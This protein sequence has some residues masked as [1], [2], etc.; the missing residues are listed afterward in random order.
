MNSKT[1]ITTAIPYVNAAPHIGFA[2]EAVQG[3]TYARFQR[4]ISND[5]FLAFGS[6]E[7][8][9]KNVQAAEKE[10]LKT[11]ELVD[12]YAKTFESLKDA[13]GLTWDVFNRT[14]KEHHFKG[15]QKLWSLCKS[16][17]IYKKK[18]KGL[19]CVGCELF[20]TPDELVDGKCPEHLTVPDEVEEENYFFK[21]SNY[22]KFLE[23]LIES[24]KLKIT[25][26]TRKNEVLSFIKSGLEDFSISRSKERAKGWGVPVP[27]DESQVIYVWFDALTTYLTSLGFGTD[28]E[29]LYKKYW[30]EKDQIVQI[31]GKGII[32]FHAVYWPAMLSSAGLNIA[33][34][35]FVH[36]YITV[37]GQKISKSLGN[38]IDPFELVEKYGIDP[39]RYYLLREIPSYGDGD[40]A[41]KRFI[42]L[43]NG[44]L[45]NGLGNLVARVAK[46]ADGNDA[47][48][49]APE[50][51]T[52]EVENH[53]NNFEFDQALRFIW[54]QVG[55]ADKYLNEKQ[56]W[57]MEG[58]EKQ[59]VLT[60]VIEKIR[61]IAYD[62]Q[63]FLPETAEKIQ[64]QFDGKIKVA[65]SLFPRI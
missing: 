5:T 26:Q 33:D 30:E 15:A 1:Y 55:L 51:F 19:Y 9:L 18:Y 46:L 61:Q 58:K 38:T 43:Y 39:V 27:G 22:Q 54:E 41:E 52:T 34:E 24:D 56:P 23:D 64:N 36:G 29:E 49:D 17:D 62:L 8:S 48:G 45:A 6:D 53:L 3:D 25:P 44:E 32:R 50:K 20:Y 42:D 7:N 60:E 40:F 57:K 10:G 4:L 2:L 65:D 63:P 14:S 16:E 47:V 59:V 12:K 31:I 21:L 35:L 28:N 37:D 11:E 13:L